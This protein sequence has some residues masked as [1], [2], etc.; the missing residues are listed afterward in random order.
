VAN[1]LCRRYVFYEG[2]MKKTV[3]SIVCLA[4]LIIVSWFQ[5]PVWIS[6]VYGNSVS[7]LAN[8]ALFGDS[9]GALNTL[10]SGLALGGIITSIFLQSQE[11]RETR[12]EIKGQK[13][14][15]KL[16]TKAMDKQV[17]ETTF[18]QLLQLHNEIVQ[19]LKTEED[20]G[21]KQHIVN[22]RD[23][24]RI[25]FI[26][27]FTQKGYIFDYY[28]MFGEDLY[29]DDIGSQ[30]LKFHRVYGNMIGHYFRNIYQILKYIEQS[31]VDDKKFYSNLLRAQLSDY[32]LG[33][34]FYNC[35]SDLGNSKFKLLIEKYEFFEHINQLNRIE[36]HE[37]AMYSVKAYG[38]TNKV[39]IQL[40]TLNT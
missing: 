39:F 16:Q 31:N 21:G 10:F 33:L 23:V 13:E 37:I 12:A 14:E 40:H 20:S 27:K 8:K 29:A 24:F 17:F 5:Y 7:E 6:S 22:G 11:L 28:C 35:L 3:V 18:F 34:L 32:E 15:F 26:D 2:I 1:V 9:F 38:S 25:L 19:S 36:G 4:T 30:Y